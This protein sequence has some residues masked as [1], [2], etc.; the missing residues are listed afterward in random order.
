MNN[1]IKDLTRAASYR[2]VGWLDD[3]VAGDG[4]TGSL[5][6]RFN[7]DPGSRLEREL[8]PWRRQHVRRLR[9]R[10]GRTDRRRR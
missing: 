4:G 5:R 7:G 9:H 10:H 3:D 8:R 2:E 6:Q 1:R